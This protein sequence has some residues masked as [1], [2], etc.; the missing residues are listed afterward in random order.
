MN[1]FLTEDGVLKLG[2]YG[3]ASQSECF[4]IKNWDCDGVRSFAPEVLKRVFKLKSDVWS[5]GISLIE[6]MGIRPYYEYETNHLPAVYNRNALPFHNREINSVDLIVFL[7]KFFKM[8]VYERWS[9]SEL[10][11]VSVT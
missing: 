9:V 8:D 10:M 3:L 4:S 6:M 7:H 11:N 2:Y 5:F 1:L